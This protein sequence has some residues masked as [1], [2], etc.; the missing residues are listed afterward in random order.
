MV[1]AD[2]ASFNGLNLSAGLAFRR[3]TDD[4]NADFFV[5]GTGNLPG[6]AEYEQ[7]FQT[8]YWGIYGGADGSIDLGNNFA[9]NL[10]GEAG[11]YYAH[12]S[13]DGRYVSDQGNWPADPPI[14]QSLSLDNGEWAYILSGRAE[15]A[16]KMGNFELAGYVQGDYYSY[17]PEIKYN[18][19]VQAPIAQLGG[20]QSGTEIGSGTAMSWTAGVVLRAEF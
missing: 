1:T 15:L 4:F 11:V 17:V 16:K 20:G 8:D 2:P 19:T 9:L 7:E 13:Y 6:R 14:N 5:P 12:A 3:L 18:N 10:D